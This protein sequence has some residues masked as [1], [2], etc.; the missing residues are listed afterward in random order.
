[1]SISYVQVQGIP[2]K[3]SHSVRSFL[4]VPAVSTVTQ[5]WTS[6]K[7]LWRIQYVDSTT[8]SVSISRNLLTI[9]PSTI[10]VNPSKEWCWLMGSANSLLFHSFCTRISFWRASKQAM[11]GFVGSNYNSYCQPW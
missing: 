9:Y 6:I 4:C 2:L 5:G 10:T 7:H 1:L 8:Y 11:T 3:A